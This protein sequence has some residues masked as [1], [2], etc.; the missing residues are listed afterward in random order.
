MDDPGLIYNNLPVAC[1]GENYLKNSTNVD[2]ALIWVL[3]LAV[4]HRTLDVPRLYR[5]EIEG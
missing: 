2:D 5:P 3:R 1:Y 4:T